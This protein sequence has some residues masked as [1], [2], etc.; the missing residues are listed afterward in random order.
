MRIAAF[1]L[2]LV[3]AVSALAEVR[4]QPGDSGAALDAGAQAAD[5]SAAVSISDGGPAA[6]DAPA[7][8]R[9]ERARA[10]QDIDGRER[11]RIAEA[12]RAEAVNR[13]LIDDEDRRLAAVASAQQA[14]RDQ[15]LIC[16]GAGGTRLEEL[17]AEVQALPTEDARYEW[18]ARELARVQWHTLR[19]WHALWRQPAG[20][21]APGKALRGNLATL[22]ESFASDAAR[23]EANRRRLHQA[24]EELDREFAHH[25]ETCA[26]V[27]FQRE[28]WLAERRRE[29]FAALGQERRAAIFDL[30]ERTA[31][32]VRV[33]AV[34][35]YI[36]VLHWLR[37]RYQDLVRITRVMRDVSVLGHVLWWL[38]EIGVALLLLGVALRRWDQWMVAIAEGIGVH[39]HLGGWTLMLVRFADFARSF[40]PPLLVL[41]TAAFI[42]RELGGAS[43]P[44]EVRVL[45]I[46]VFW[47]AALRAQQRL[48]EQAVRHAGVLWAEREAREDDYASDSGD[49]HVEG[50][51]PGQ[52]GDAAQTAAAT[53]GEPAVALFART[54]H[55]LT[56]Y[57]IV[58]MITVELAR[59]ATGRA[60]IYELA[61]LLFW[62]GLV[63]MAVY[64]LRVWRPWIVREYVK[65]SSE[66]GWLTEL[67]TR[68]AQRFYGILVLAVALVIVLVRQ[69]ARFIRRNLSDLDTTKRL[70]AFLFRRQVEKH[71]LE[72]GAVLG[73][74]HDLPPDLLA[75]FP[76]GPLDPGDRPVKPAFL[77]DIKR[78]FTTW[79]A[80]QM[81]GSVVLVGAPGM[82]KSTAMR[83]L[84]STL[85]EP[86]P[87]YKVVDRYTQPE[88]LITGLA[89]LIGLARVPTDEA[90]FAAELSSY[91]E[92]HG[93]RVIALDNCHNFFL[94]KV[95]GFA[96]WE[97]FT[98]I[99]NQTCHRVFW[100][101]SFNAASWD[102]LK[103]IAGGVSYFRR[104]VHMP[105]WT[106]EELRR[107]ILTRMRRAGYRVSFTDLLVTRMHG[108]KA[109]S[110]II[111]TSQGYFRLLWDFT[112]GNPRVACHFW[113]RS[114][115][116]DADKKRVRV[117]LFAA[118]RIE[119]LERLPD[120][121]AFVL[122]ALI[123]H[124]SI[125]DEELATVS[126]T[127]LEF[128]RF[129]LQ[130]C[131]EH[132]YMWRTQHTD[133]TK[134]TTHWQ[135]SIIR[136][137]K[138]RHLLYS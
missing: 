33:E 79:Q 20:A 97:T 24:A 129:A 2:F 75:E 115:V 105:A 21:P 90:T 64:C 10:G 114:L 138:R 46:F 47:V 132:G 49:S 51:L 66:D 136:Y 26:Q 113:L 96:A 7:E 133:R 37:G 12:E 107:L 106:D 55:A 13:Q 42:H 28:R 41:A 102:Y 70:L 123:E 120:E 117:H 18:V 109:S 27:L 60:V 14:F 118:P 58:A 56:W 8:E 22:P 71:A 135:Q 30:R 125:T 86:V 134:L 121:I 68:H 67:T 82:G 32:E 84:Q 99:V 112:N 83:L 17:A 59:L 74:M 103:N 29:L 72:R 40:G 34:H 128:A 1:F 9:P 35:L 48:L 54:W 65:R 92:A 93:R 104:V 39:L 63:P 91:L 108:V 100:V 95:G 5:A 4:A 31:D 23:L 122:A 62:W 16:L 80:E 81:E 50:S 11:A 89:R 15:N 111:R 85:G 76:T 77:D 36:E 88:A 98:R 3:S 38:L 73:K 127:S 19:A 6:L 25:L 87:V 53:P 130:Y 57:A 110:Q 44:V 126:N 101:M 78:A 131:R 43:A 119:E 124:E 45:Y 61:C 69:I 94:R 116:P 52:E 137:L